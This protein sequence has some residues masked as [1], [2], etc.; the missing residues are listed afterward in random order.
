MSKC[1]A[2]FRLDRPCACAFSLVELIIVVAIMAVIGAMAASR[3]SNRVTDASITKLE[4]DVL[5]LNNALDFYAAEHGGDYP[6]PEQII[7]QLLTFTDAAGSASPTKTTQHIFG[8]YLR[9][10]PP[11]LL[12]NTDDNDTIVPDTGDHATAGWVYDASTGN[13]QPN[14]TESQLVALDVTDAAIKQILNKSSIIK[15]DP[16]SP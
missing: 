10:I 3:M 13:I 1:L 14:V 11:M 2:P 16:A 8:P 4:A 15:A 5:V 12:L 7:T 6:D 9:S